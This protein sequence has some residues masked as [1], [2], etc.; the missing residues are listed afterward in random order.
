MSMNKKM[1]IKNFSNTEE[2]TAEKVGETVAS[3]SFFREI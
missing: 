3:I 1:Q 2:L